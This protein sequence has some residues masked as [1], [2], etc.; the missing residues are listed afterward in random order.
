M[1]I[2]SITKMNRYERKIPSPSHR[3]FEP[4]G[5]LEPCKVGSHIRFQPCYKDSRICFRALVLSKSK[6]AEHDQQYGE[7][8][9]KKTHFAKPKSAIFSTAVSPFVDSKIFCSS[10]DTKREERNERKEAV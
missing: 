6:I 4:V 5:L 2:L 3:T 7:M 1:S 9:K 8:E 10:N